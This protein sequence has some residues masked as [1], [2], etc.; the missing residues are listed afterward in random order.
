ME[1]ALEAGEE[2][3]SLVV[4]AAGGVVV[5]DTEAGPRVLL[6]HRAKYDDWTF[7]KG[8]AEDGETDEECALREVGEETML[9]CRLARPLPTTRYVD[10][11]GRPKLV[12]WWVMEPIGDPHAAGASNEVDE[13]RWLTPEEARALLTYRRDHDVLDAV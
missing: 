4:R 1:A 6:V 9:R 7:P 11:K 12:R 10:A 2:G 5:R 3:V 8:K 13:V